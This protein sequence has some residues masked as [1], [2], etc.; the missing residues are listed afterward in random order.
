MSHCSMR[1]YPTGP[2]A[3][4][5]NEEAGRHRVL[6]KCGC[7]IPLPA[8]TE[9]LR[10]SRRGKG[11]DRAPEAGPKGRRT[12]RGSKGD[13]PAGEPLGGPHQISERRRAEG[14]ALGGEPRGAG[15]VPGRDGRREARD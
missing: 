7:I 12:G 13:G 3:W 15:P 6:R 5:H 2:W 14:V 11:P 10:C 4:A 9:A 1:L 8:L